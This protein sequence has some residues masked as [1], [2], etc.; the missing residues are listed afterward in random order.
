MF[1][2]FSDVLGPKSFYLL[3]AFDLLGTVVFAMSGALLAYEQRRNVLYG[4]LYA[5]L[6]AVG[7]GTL[8][9]LLLGQ[10]SVFWMRSPV[11]LWL[12]ST[13]GLLAFALAHLIRLRRQHF[14]LADDI[15]LAIFTVVGS[16][17]TMSAIAA[18]PHAYASGWTMW[19]MPPI[20]G[21]FT[22]TAGGLMRDMIG[23]NAP[24]VLQHPSYAIASLTGGSI[25]LALV[26]LGV[27]AFYA[28]VIP[29]AFIILMLPIPDHDVLKL[30]VCVRHLS[31]RIGWK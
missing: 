7:G 14:W 16:Q 31:N 22:G 10:P 29:I 15:S 3:H 26:S 9:D 2:E 19:L 28:I 21:L 12:A 13:A 4:F 1:S 23:A 8:R 25:Y 11:Y 18:A 17:V 24:D 30:N 20:M 27:S 5:V 6:T